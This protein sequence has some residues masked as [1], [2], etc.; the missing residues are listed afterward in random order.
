MAH[1]LIDIASQFD[2]KDLITAADGSAG[3][4]AVLASIANSVANGS[5][6]NPYI[7]DGVKRLFATDHSVVDN[8]FTQ[9]KAAF[10]G[11]NNDTKPAI[12]AGGIFGATH[13]ASVIAG[14]VILGAHNANVGT[15]DGKPTLVH[16][17]TGLTAI[18][19]WSAGARWHT[20]KGKGKA[21]KAS[22]FGDSRYIDAPNANRIL[23][24]GSTQWC[25]SHGADR[26]ACPIDCLIGI[27]V[28]DSLVPYSEK[29]ML[30]QQVGNFVQW[31]G[32]ALM[33][34]SPSESPT[35]TATTSSNASVTDSEKAKV[36]DDA[37]S[38]LDALAMIA[39]RLGKAEYD[40]QVKVVETERDKA[41][42][43]V[44]NKAKAIADAQ[45]VLDELAIEITAFELVKARLP[46]QV[47]G[48]QVKAY[49]DAQTKAQVTLDKLTK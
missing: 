33:G 26:S 17:N 31:Y 14:R 30:A 7:D 24:L 9:L 16:A 36:N 18:Q 21:R 6:D 29:P 28:V 11:G 35:P 5:V 13:N 44:D 15:K 3:D 8:A 37:Q 48:A 40:K 34:L 46:K 23:P 12:F 45:V 32:D 25:A 38:E 2:A 4:K 41:L 20:V 43:A 27:A 49:A 10:K 47:A 39:K 22:A 42:Q 1:T 19:R